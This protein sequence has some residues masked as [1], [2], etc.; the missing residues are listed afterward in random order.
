MNIMKKSFTRIDFNDYYITNECDRVI[1][2][3]KRNN[4][5]KGVGNAFNQI[6]GIKNEYL[7]KMKIFIDEEINQEN[8]LYAQYEKIYFLRQ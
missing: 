5:I 4:S 7:G 6:Q 1:Q 8:K 2:Y 3:A